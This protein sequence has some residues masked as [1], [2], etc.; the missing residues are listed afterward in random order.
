MTPFEVAYFFWE[1]MFWLFAIP[2]GCVA[3]AVIV[4][5]VGIDLY[6]WLKFLISRR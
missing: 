3:S 6:H 2:V 1:L 4:M 5:K